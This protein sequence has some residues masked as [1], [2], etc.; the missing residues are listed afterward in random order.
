MIDAKRDDLIKEALKE[1]LLGG[2]LTSEA[3]FTENEWGSAILLAK[4]DGILAGTSEFQRVFELIDPEVTF[5]NIAAEG[6]WIKQGEP[7][8]QIKGRFLSILKAERTAL[9]LIQR[10]SGIATATRAH[11]DAVKPYTSQVVDTRKTAPGLR[12]FDKKAVRIGGGKNHRF[13]LYDAVMIKDNHIDAV[14]NL[15]EAVRKVKACVGHMVKIEVEIRKLEELESAIL[16]GADVVLLDN[17]SIQDMT[18]AVKRVN[19]R[20]LVEASGNMTLDRVHRVA[21]T[22]VDLISVG[23][24]THSVRAL[25]MSLRI[26]I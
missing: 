12:W 15:E 10:M 19:G 4:D 16:A 21:A 14:G 22:G 9:N 3:L 8:M 20:V 26:D 1:D 25:D 18:E 5:E 11:V 7:L 2:D 23:A 13:G 17:M 24:L 6:T